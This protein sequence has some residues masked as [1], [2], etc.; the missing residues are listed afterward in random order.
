[1][2]VDVIRS[3]DGST[4]PWFPMYEKGD[5]PKGYDVI[6]HDECSADIKEMSYVHNIVGA[7]KK[8]LP[9]VNLHCAMH[10]YRTGT[11]LW[12]ELLGLQSSGHGPQ[13]PIALDFSGA[14]HPITEG[15]GNWTTIN[16]ELYN[17]V[18]ESLIPPSRWYW[19]VRSS[20]TE[21]CRTR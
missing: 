8:G 19:G 10:S 17:N 1:M 18:K 3:K 9:A 14:T 2:Q 15:M 4:K 21:R 5:W 7:H 20:G 6:I 13:L 16:E 11:D 12:F